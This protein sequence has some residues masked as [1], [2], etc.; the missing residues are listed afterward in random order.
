[1]STAA[2]IERS[3]YLSALQDTGTF[4]SLAPGVAPAQRGLQFDAAVRLMQSRRNVS[5]RRLV[6]PGPTQQ[7]LSAILSA[8]AAAPDHGLLMPWRFVVVPIAKRHLLAEAFA[9]ALVDRDPGATL[10]QIE[11][12]RDKAYRA[13]Y[14]MLAIVRL[15]AA[16]QTIPDAERLV[17]LGCAIQNVLLA[18]TAAGFGSGLTSGQSMA[19]PRL[20]AVCG[21]GDN[22]QLV[23]CVNVGTVAT[24][25][26][27]RIRSEAG[28][29]VTELTE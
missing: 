5:P 11:A 25:K 29:F 27:S 26:K 7:Q 28:A 12:A 9:L 16:D 24:P 10:E 17:S 4:P 15:G 3:G 21:V 22:E 18:A 6:E 23:C 8:A 14:L 19:S 20:S 1:M 13:P 2:P